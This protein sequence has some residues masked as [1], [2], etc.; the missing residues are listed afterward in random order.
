MFSLVK[1][2]DLLFFSKSYL[3]KPQL[4]CLPGA[5][6]KQQNEGKL[7]PTHSKKVF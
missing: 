7:V 6:K 2:N 4:S 5:Y 1:K 3:K